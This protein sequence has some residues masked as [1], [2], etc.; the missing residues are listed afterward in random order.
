VTH[1]NFS[2]GLCGPGIGPEIMTGRL[3]SPMGDYHHQ[4]VECTVSALIATRQWKGYTGRTCS[5]FFFLTGI[6]EE[7]GD[8][9]R[10]YHS[11]FSTGRRTDYTVCS[12][13]KGEA[14]ATSS[15]HRVYSI[16]QWTIDY[17]HR[18]HHRHSTG[19]PG[20]L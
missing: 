4:H 11:V 10:F 16:V 13:H 18:H 12:S 5:D 7:L 2:S 17:S 19:R 3:G 6:A 15:D 20:R 9:R 1:D 8:F 14:T